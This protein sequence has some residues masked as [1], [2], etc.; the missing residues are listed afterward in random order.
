MYF[1]TC[2]LSGRTFFAVLSFYTSVGL[3]LKGW[4]A[5]E[6]NLFKYF[7][8]EMGLLNKRLSFSG[9]P[10]RRV[11]SEEEKQKERVISSVLL[12]RQEVN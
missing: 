6:G 3:E 5:V 8:A 7:S 1:M 12:C 4:V 11:Q 2:L 10:P 9:K